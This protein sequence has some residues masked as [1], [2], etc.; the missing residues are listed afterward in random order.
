[1][2]RPQG[3]GY[4]GKKSHATYG[5]L[6]VSLTPRVAVLP[7]DNCSALFHFLC[8]KRK[9]V[10]V[11]IADRLDVLREFDSAR[12]WE[13]LDDER[14]CLLCERQFAGRHIDFVSDSTGQVRLHCPS[15]DCKGTPR[16]WVYLNDPRVVS[17]D[18][19]AS[20]PFFALP[21]TA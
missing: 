8:V 19:K 11:P 15:F 13:S 3:D 2:R 5:G 16:E 1:M 10:H 14:I 12:R 6:R 21:A 17:R 4:R 9:L 18:G 20:T 7:K